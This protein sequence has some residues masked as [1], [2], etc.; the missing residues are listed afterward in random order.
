V[1]Y[2]ADEDSQEYF[3]KLQN[4]VQPRTFQRTTGP[5]TGVNFVITGTLALGS[6]DE[7]AAKLVALGAKEQSSVGKDTTYL[8]VGDNPGASKLTKAQKLGTQMLDA[9]ALNKLLQQ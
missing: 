8:V 4:Y 5:L 2:F 9:A 7:A 6:R 1:A 3:M